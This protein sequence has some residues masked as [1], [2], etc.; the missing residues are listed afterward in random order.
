MTER[1]FD[2]ERVDVDR[3]SIDYVALS[4]EAAQPLAGFIDRL[5]INGFALPNQ[6]QLALP[7]ETVNVASK[8]LLDFWT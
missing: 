2:H 8:I 3:L 7:R 4:F 6:S 1:P 5:A